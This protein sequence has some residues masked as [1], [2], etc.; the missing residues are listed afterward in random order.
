MSLQVR[1][2]DPQVGRDDMR[3]QPRAPAE[4]LLAGVR[5]ARILRRGRQASLEDLPLQVAD[6]PSQAPARDVSIPAWTACPRWK[7]PSDLRAV[8]GTVAEA[9]RTD[10]PL[11]NGTWCS[12]RAQ[13]P[14]HDGA[15]NPIERDGLY[16]IAALEPGEGAAERTTS[17][18]PVDRAHRAHRP[19]GAKC[20]RHPPSKKVPSRSRR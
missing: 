1:Y 16:H 8:E 17:L 18:K 7:T 5:N 9:R 2:A 3:P 14:L 11:S 15:A 20:P 10:R 13:H 19:A 12:T 6:L 4:F